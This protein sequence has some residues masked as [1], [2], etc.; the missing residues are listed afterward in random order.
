RALICADT[1]TSRGGRLGDPMAFL[2]YDPTLNH[3]SQAKLAALDF[4]HLLPSHGPAIMN[5]GKAK[6][7]EYGSK[8]IKRP[9]FGGRI[10]VAK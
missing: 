10:A 7:Q 3:Q 2:T 6:A 1:F 4:D 5:D 8:R 9:L